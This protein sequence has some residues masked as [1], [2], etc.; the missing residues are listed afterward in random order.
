MSSKPDVHTTR[1]VLVAEYDANNWALRL[2][3][4][5]NDRIDEITTYEEGAKEYH[6]RTISRHYE[7]GI[8]I[9]V[10]IAYHFHDGNSLMRLKMLF[11]DGARHICR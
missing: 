9:A 10:T 11:F 5:A 6:T 8:Q 7:G 1:N 2:E 4:C 3:R